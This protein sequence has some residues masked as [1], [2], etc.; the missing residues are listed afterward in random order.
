MQVSVDQAYAR[1]KGKSV[2]II[3]ACFGTEGSFAR[4]STGLKIH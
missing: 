1:I 4:P 2:E 3:T